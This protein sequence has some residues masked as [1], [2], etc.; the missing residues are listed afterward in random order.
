MSMQLAFTS[1]ISYRRK[2][3]LVLVPKEYRESMQLF[4]G[5]RVVIRVD[6]KFKYRGK[7]TVIDGRVYVTLPKSALGLKALQPYHIFRIEVD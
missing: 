1:K 4:K 6:E 3:V 7:I 2:Q 5:K